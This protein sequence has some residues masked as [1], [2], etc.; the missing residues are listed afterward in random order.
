[1]HNKLQRMQRKI[2]LQLWKYWSLQWLS[3]YITT[4]VS[5]DLLI[6]L[7]TLLKT[8]EIFIFD[9]PLFSH[10]VSIFGENINLSHFCCSIGYTLYETKIGK[11]ILRLKRGVY[12]SHTTTGSRDID[13]WTYF[14]HFQP[15]CQFKPFLFVQRVNIITLIEKWVF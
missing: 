2:L 3:R 8:T 13:F 7:I 10:Q 11:W 15:K 14:R 12:E 9:S 1:M 4:I 6:N 5:L